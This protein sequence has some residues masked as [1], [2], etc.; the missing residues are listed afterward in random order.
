MRVVRQTISVGRGWQVS[1]RDDDRGPGVRGDVLGDAPLE[2]SRQ[3]AEPSRSDNHHVVTAVLGDPLDCHCGIS[4]R[5]DENGREYFK[6][7]SLPRAVMKFRQG[8]GRLIRT[9]T[10]RGA[11]ICLDSRVLKMGYGKAFLRS[12]PT[13]K[14]IQNLNELKQF[15]SPPEAA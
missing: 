2:E 5:L 13:C 14:K 1:A 6:D 3:G 10:D 4:S 7:W 9:S 15:F 8:F 11:V 12:L